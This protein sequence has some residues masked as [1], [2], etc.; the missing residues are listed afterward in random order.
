MNTGFPCGE[1]PGDAFL[2]W[3]RFAQG[4]ADLDVTSLLRRAVRRADFGDAE[5]GAYGAPFPSREHRLA[6]RIFPRLV[7]TRPDHAGAFDNRRAAEVLR[8]LDLPV[9]PIWG[10]A[11]PITGPWEP[12]VRQLFARVEPTRWI[13]GA[14][15]FLQ[16]DAGEEVASLIAARVARG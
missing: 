9:L 1:P 7:P 4:R 6:A 12:R 13:S 3:R 2:A 11:D 5:A 14:G 16:E 8:T 10:D 15:H